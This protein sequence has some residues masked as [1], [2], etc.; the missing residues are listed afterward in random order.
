MRTAILETGAPLGRLKERHG[1]Y[2][3]MMMRMPAPIAPQLSFFTARV[4]EDAPELSLDAFDG[5]HSGDGRPRSSRGESLLQPHT[6][7]ARASRA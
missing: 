7:S 2:P 1:D 3:A 4:C 5:L 6:L